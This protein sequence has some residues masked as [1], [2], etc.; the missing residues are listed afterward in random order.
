MTKSVMHLL[1]IVLIS[2]SFVTGCVTTSDKN[3]IA[4]GNQYAKDGLLREAAESY[5]KALAKKYKKSTA[6][7]NLGLV[8]VKM[9]EYKAAI[10]HLEKS[11]SKY[12]SDFDANFF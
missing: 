12:E 4:I 7:R 1:M 5:K 11:M 2:S 8:L 9:G 3:Y 10:R 6:N